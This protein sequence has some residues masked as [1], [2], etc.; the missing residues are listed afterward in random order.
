[1]ATPI[2]HTRNTLLIAALAATVV[3]GCTRPSQAIIDD[4]AYRCKA[5]ASVIRQENCLNQYRSLGYIPNTPYQYTPPA[6]R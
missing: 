3:G 6:T 4:L 1:M 5:A 2:P